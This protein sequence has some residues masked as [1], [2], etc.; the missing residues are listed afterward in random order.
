MA[1]WGRP[2]LDFPCFQ[3]GC[4]I[5]KIGLARRLANTPRLAA[6]G[7]PLKRGITHVRVEKVGGMIPVRVEKVPS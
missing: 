7:T 1:V 5:L 6:L 4:Y 3:Q 2:R